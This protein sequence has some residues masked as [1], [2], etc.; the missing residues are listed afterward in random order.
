M[1]ILHGYMMSLR[2]YVSAGGWVLRNSNKLPKK[3]INKNILQQEMTKSGMFHLL[4]N[5]YDFFLKRNSLYLIIFEL[6]LITC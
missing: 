5:G 4:Q 6:A 3:K 1:L 2:G